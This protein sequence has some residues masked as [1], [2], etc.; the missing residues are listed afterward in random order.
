MY[1]S[2]TSNYAEV[3]GENG[4]VLF[5]TSKIG[6]DVNLPNSR[7]IVAFSPPSDSN[8]TVKTS[9][10]CTCIL[11][12]SCNFHPKTYGQCSMILENMHGSMS[13][14]LEGTG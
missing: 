10:T 4:T 13:T 1:R 8:G 3:I 6:D 14:L 2:E 9:Q 7:P 12:L 5:T 11:I